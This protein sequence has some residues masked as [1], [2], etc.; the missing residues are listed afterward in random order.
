MMGRHLMEKVQVRRVLDAEE[1]SAIQRCQQGDVEALGILISRYQSTALR[2]AF[3]LTGSQMLAEDILQ[4][5]FLAAY[6]AMPRFDLSRPFGPWLY[7]IVTNTARM[8]HRVKE[9]HL[10]LSLDEALEQGVH[11]DASQEGLPGPEEHTERQ[12]V[13]EALGDIL[14]ALTTAQREAIVLRYYH[15]FTDR[16]IAE[17]VGCRVAA[18]RQRIYGGLHTLKKLISQRS[19][20][21]LDER[22]TSAS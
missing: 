22:F 16:E 4:E 20:W 9:R 18:A 21:L 5:A 12:E 3:L 17:I 14:A 19:P 6:R 11:L 13:R 8:H 2:L 15:E 7:R 1:K 10:T